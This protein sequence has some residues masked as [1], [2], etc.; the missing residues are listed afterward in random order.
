MFAL[1]MPTY[2]CLIHPFWA[3]FSYFSSSRKN[4]ISIE[5]FHNWN[6]WRLHYTAEIWVLISWV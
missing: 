4:I 5:L 6:L 3:S 2:V 1:N